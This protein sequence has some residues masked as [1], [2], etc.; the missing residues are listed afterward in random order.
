MNA[1]YMYVRAF[2]LVKQEADSL[3]ISLEPQITLMENLHTLDV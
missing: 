3:H 2:E 1:T